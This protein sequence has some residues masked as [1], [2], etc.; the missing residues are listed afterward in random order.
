ML[1]TFYFSYRI[2]QKLCFGVTGAKFTPFPEKKKRKKLDN[3]Y[4]IIVIKTVHIRQ[5]RTMKIERGKP[6]L[7]PLGC[8]EETQTEQGGLLELS[9]RIRVGRANGWDCTEQSARENR[10]ALRESLKAMQRVSCSHC[11]GPRFPDQGIKIP[12][13]TWH[14]QKKKNK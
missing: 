6:Q 13:A 10:V 4:E 7:S 8:E 3:K 2:S 1:E 5:Q 9:G 11:R 14:A 12:Q